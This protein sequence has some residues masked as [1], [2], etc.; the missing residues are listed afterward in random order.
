M[1]PWEEGTRRAGYA[2]RFQKVVRTARQLFAE[3][4]PIE[5]IVQQ[6]KPDAGKMKIDAER[7]QKWVSPGL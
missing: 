4:V 7:I 1:S 3:G 2:A 6:L 5:D